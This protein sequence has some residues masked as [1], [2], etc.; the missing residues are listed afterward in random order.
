[1]LFFFSDSSLPSFIFNH[2]SLPNLPYVIRLTQT[3]DHILPL[4]LTNITGHWYSHSWSWPWKTDWTTPLAERA[5]METI[6]HPSTLPSKERMFEDWNANPVHR[7]SDPP[8]LP[9]TQPS[10]HNTLHPFVTGVLETSSRRLQCTAFQ[11]ITGHSFQGDYSLHHR[12]TAPDNTICPHCT[13]NRFYNLW[14]ILVVCHHH[15]IHCNRL[16]IN[17]S[18]SLHTLFSTKLG[19]QCLCEFLKATNTLLRPLPP[20]LTSPGTLRKCPPPPLLIPH[21][22]L[23]I[24]L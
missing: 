20:G 19:G 16:I 18:L 23:F 11:A 17:H 7:D 15:T 1:V 12:P 21:G 3:L 14:H 10:T 9:F 8:Y 6:H 24:L 2:R 13:G 4:R 22:H 5:T